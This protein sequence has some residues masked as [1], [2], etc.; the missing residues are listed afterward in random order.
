MAKVAK[1]KQSKKDTKSRREARS[2]SEVKDQMTTP[3]RAGFRRRWVNDTRNRLQL[4]QSAG[5]AVVLEETPVGDEGV[6][7]QNQSIGGGARKYVGSD[8]EGK[9]LYAILMEIPETDAREVDKYKQ[10]NVDATEQAI[11]EELQ[12]KNKYGEFK[13]TVSK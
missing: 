6:V 9:P 10:E 7:N 1:K 8:E 4:F 11:Y 12:A 2:I 5:W 13:V 3:Q